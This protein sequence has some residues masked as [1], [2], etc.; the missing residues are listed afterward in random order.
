MGVF[1]T[2]HRLNLSEEWLWYAANQASA[3]L[4]LAWG[5]SCTAIAVGTYFVPNISDTMYFSI[6]LGAII[7]GAFV[8]I[9]SSFLILIKLQQKGQGS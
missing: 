5:L 8:V 3:K 7:G 6:N 9:L 4:L 1:A 2:A